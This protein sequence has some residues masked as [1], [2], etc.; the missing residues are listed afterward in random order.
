MPIPERVL[1]NS[2]WMFANRRIGKTHKISF[3]P[4]R[5]FLSDKKLWFKKCTVITSMITGP[6]EPV[7]EYFWCDRKEFLLNEIKG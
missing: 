1:S 5:C 4:R 6:G 2:E 3:I 7:F